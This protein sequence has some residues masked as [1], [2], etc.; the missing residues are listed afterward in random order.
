MTHSTQIT[1]HSGADGTP[2]NSLDFVRYALEIGADAL[3][4]DVRRAPDGTLALGHDCA[5]QDAPALREAFALLTGHSVTVNCD[6]KESGLEQ[7][8]VQLAQQAGIVDQLVFSGAV[9]PDHVEANAQVY[10]NIEECVPD[11]YDRCKA[12]P[13]YRLYAA[14]CACERCAESDVQTLNVSERIIDDAFLDVLAQNGIA[15]SV[16]T[17]NEPER[18]VYFLQ[19]GVRNLTTRRPVKAMELRQSEGAHV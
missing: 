3:E 5:E 10:W 19:R 8:V 18:M 14:Q 6:L 2:E 17:V 15:L 7:E 9:D 4:V 11:V 12:D 16:W 13:A 1:A